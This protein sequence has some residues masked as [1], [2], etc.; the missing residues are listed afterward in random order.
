MDPDAHA[1]AER[2]KMR[3]QILMMNKSE[4][5]KKQQFKVH[6]DR[7]HKRQF[8]KLVDR[9]EKRLVK[10]DARYNEKKREKFRSEMQRQH[11]FDRY[12]QRKKG[13]PYTDRVYTAK[14]FKPVYNYIASKIIDTAMGVAKTPIPVNRKKCKDFDDYY[15]HPKVIEQRKL[16]QKMYKQALDHQNA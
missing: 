10:K 7:F 1:N 16:A 12:K 3:R 6:V 14:A 13:D 5:V 4:V 2:R 11:I 15:I 8:R 9:E